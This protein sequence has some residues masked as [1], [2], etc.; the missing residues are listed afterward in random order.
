MKISFF[1]LRLNTQFHLHISG[2]MLSSGCQ[3]L[4]SAPLGTPSPFLDEALEDAPDYK[5]FSLTG[6]SEVMKFC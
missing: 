2:T 1:R 5:T 3:I 4:E 6:K